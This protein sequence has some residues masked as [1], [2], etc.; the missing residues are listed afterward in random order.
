M[1]PFGPNK[2][3]RRFA[4]AG[5][6]RIPQGYFWHRPPPTCERGQSSTL[7]AEVLGFNRFQ[8]ALFRILAK[9]NRK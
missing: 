2:R 9:P 8:A 3:P 5:P 7:Y 1:V 6:R 4:V